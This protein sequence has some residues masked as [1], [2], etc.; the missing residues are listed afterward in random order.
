MR[1]HENTLMDELE[2]GE[3]AIT[4]QLLSILL[5]RRKNSIYSKNNSKLLTQKGRKLFLEWQ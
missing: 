1:A 3:E 2:Q 5:K 4:A